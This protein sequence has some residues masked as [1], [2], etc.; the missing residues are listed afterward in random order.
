MY[1]KGKDIS[2]KKYL[3]AFVFVSSVLGELFPAAEF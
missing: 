1:R 3:A 2:K